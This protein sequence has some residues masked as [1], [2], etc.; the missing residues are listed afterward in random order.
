MFLVDGAASMLTDWQPLVDVHAVP[1]KLSLNDL[2]RGRRAIYL[3]VKYQLKVSEI[4]G[5]FPLEADCRG[6]HKLEMKSSDLGR[7]K[8]KQ[9]TTAP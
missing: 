1:L 9:Q 6:I 5:F 7:F 8:I 3:S 2:V 4:A